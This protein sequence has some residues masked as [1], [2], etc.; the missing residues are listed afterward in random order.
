MATIDG[1]RRNP[2]QMAIRGQ[3]LSLM[4]VVGKGVSYDSIDTLQCYDPNTLQ[5]LD[6]AVIS[7]TPGTSASL[8]KILLNFNRDQILD[9]LNGD[10]EN[11]T[12]E[13][14]RDISNQLV[15]ALVG[16]RTEGDIP[17]ILGYLNLEL[18]RKGSSR[19]DGDER[20]K[21]GKLETVRL[22][23]GLDNY[24]FIGERDEVFGSTGQDDKTFSFIAARENG[25]VGV[26][27]T[28]NV[29][30]H[31][32]FPAVN[33]NQKNTAAVMWQNDNSAKCTDEGCPPDTFYVLGDKPERRVSALGNQGAGSGYYRF[34][35]GYDCNT[36]ERAL[37]GRRT[38]AYIA[39]LAGQ[40]RMLAGIVDAGLATAF[41]NFHTINTWEAA[42]KEKKTGLVDNKR[43]SEMSALDLFGPGTAKLSGNE[44]LDLWLRKKRSDLV[45]GLGN[46]SY[47]TL[48][49]PSCDPTR[50]VPPL[51]EALC[52]EYIRMTDFGGLYRFR[53][54]DIS[55]GV[56][57]GAAYNPDTKRFKY[58]QLRDSELV[59]PTKFKA[60]FY[61]MTDTTTST[62]GISEGEMLSSSVTGSPMFIS[63]DGKKYHPSFLYLGYDKLDPQ[64]QET[65]RLHGLVN[66]PDYFDKWYEAK[67]PTLVV[68]LEDGVL[69]S[70]KQEYIKEVKVLAPVNKRLPGTLSAR[71]YGNVEGHH[72]DPYNFPQGNVKSEHPNQVWNFA[73]GFYRSLPVSKV[74]NDA[75][76]KAKD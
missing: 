17:Y 39:R 19:K 5:M 40:V 31:V 13:Q 59:A 36:W 44:A 53:T 12:E 74:V 24:D 2:F 18:V 69:Q 48:K 65:A 9:Y 54:D 63:S 67:E 42:F 10:L 62:G 76:G 51:E 66:T 29:F 15:Y 3:G 4:L 38:V 1:K 8:P 22:C 56:T 57:K 58:G 16:F 61:P 46:E 27:A 52:C 45:E 30:N 68:N 35:A 72:G 47:K 6:A 26:T 73:R 11:L 32:A 60:Q 43:L 20:E 7:P 55:G 50:I 37:Y 34:S 21:V 64:Q 49:T 14:Q 25:A 71:H 70:D 41:Y 33:R 28:N 75:Q 23:T